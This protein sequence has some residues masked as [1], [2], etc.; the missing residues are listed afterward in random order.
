M[1]T[2]RIHIRCTYYNQQRNDA[3]FEHIQIIEL[4]L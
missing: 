1:I 4:L 2:I 3:T